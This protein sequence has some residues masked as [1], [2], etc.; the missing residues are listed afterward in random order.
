MD[1]SEV[2]PTT[3]LLYVTILG[4]TTSKGYTARRAA[5]KSAR[6]CCRLVDEASLPCTQHHQTHLYLAATQGG[7]TAM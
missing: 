4:D 3:K 6:T 5:A 2:V 1:P 7:I